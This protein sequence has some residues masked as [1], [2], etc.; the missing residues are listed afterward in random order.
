MTYKLA[1][2]CTHLPSNTDNKCETRF[3]RNIIISTIFSLPHQSDFIPLLPPVFPH[4]LFSSLEDLLSL[5]VAICA[6]LRN[7]TK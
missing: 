2:A 3:A 5:L 1:I 4:I 6:L 7:S